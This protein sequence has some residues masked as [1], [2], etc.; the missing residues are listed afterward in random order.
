MKQTLRLL[1]AGALLAACAGPPALRPLPPVA[2]IQTLERCHRL[3]PDDAWR[4]VHT[5]SAEMPGEQTRTLIG[6]SL[7]SPEQRSIQAVLMTVEGLVLFNAVY[8]QTLEVRRALPPFDSNE[9]ARG[10]MRDVRLIFLEP[11]A[12]AVESG[13]LESGQRGCR[14]TD[15]DGR[16]VDV[17]V[18]DDGH[19]Q[20]TLYD[21]RRPLRTLSAGACR[22]D[23]NDRIPCRLNLTAHGR[24]SYRLELTLIEAE[25]V[26][27]QPVE[28][29]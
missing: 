18:H 29:E 26:Q 1:M 28:P 11:D 19:W 17:I 7:V 14:Y 13:V 6:I 12:T 22:S 25:P 10:L 16:T 21:G 15:N 2:A 23:T 8:A 9:F 3:F 27:T 24:L 5:I 20:L 4:T